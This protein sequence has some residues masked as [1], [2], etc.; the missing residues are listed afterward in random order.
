MGARPGP[1]LGARLRGR[2]RGRRAR[3][4]S[5][6]AAPPLPGRDGGKAASEPPRLRPGRSPGEVPAR[7]PGVPVEPGG[8]PP[9]AGPLAPGLRRPVHSHVSRSSQSHR[10]A[11]RPQSGRATSGRS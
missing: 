11:W 9:A 8:D 2:A 6:G 10:L 5:A 1:A 3:A 7:R 4:T